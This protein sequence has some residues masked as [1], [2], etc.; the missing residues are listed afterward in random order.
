MTFSELIKKNADEKHLQLL[1]G[2]AERSTPSTE[3][4]SCAEY[5]KKSKAFHRRLR[6]EESAIAEAL[7]TV[8]ATKAEADKAEAERIKREEAERKA[9]EAEKKR[10]EEEKRKEEERK[11]QEEA[12]RRR[13]ER[14]AAERAAR[15]EREA[16]ERAARAERA[17]QE[18]KKRTIR[19]I[20]IAAVS[21]VLVVALI[22][23]IVSISNNK[24][25]E[26]ARLEELNYGDSHISLVI[27][28]KS[29]G[30]QSY[31]NYT[32]NFKVQ[33]NNECGVDIT[34]LTCDVIFTALES[35]TELCSG[36]VWFSG[37]I[38][39][40]GTNK[41]DLELKTS[42]NELWNYSLKDLKIQ[43][44]VTGATFKDGTEKEYAGEYKTIYDGS[45]VHDPNDTSVFNMELSSN[46]GYYILTEV[47]D[48]SRTSYNIPS[49]YEGKPVSAIGSNAFDGCSLLTKVEIPNS[50]L[51]IG[52]NAFSSCSALTSV[53]IPKSV[54]SI[55]G[56]AFSYC[57]DI[58]IYCETASAPSGWDSYWDVMSYDAYYRHTVVWNCAGAQG[59][60][61]DG[62][63]WFA[64]NDGTANIIGFNNKSA[65][66]VTVP[67]EIQGYAIKEIPNELFSGCNLLSAVV[68]SNGIE[69]IGNSAFSGCK[70]LTS[71]TI[72]SS[73]KSIGENAFDGCTS[74]KNVVIPNGVLTIG[75]YAFSDC[76]SLGSIVIPDSVTT[77]GSYIF[78]KCDNLV[79][80]CVTTSQPDSWNYKWDAIEYAYWDDQLDFHT[81]VYNYGGVQ[82]V[83]DDGLWWYATND[84]SAVIAGIVN[85]SVTSLNIPTSING[86]A[87]SEL[88][89]GL[90]SGCKSL[91]NLTIP[92][93]GADITGSSN[94]H[95]GYIF[96]A[97]SYKYNADYI[98]S[99]LKNVTISGGTIIGDN[100]FYNCSSLTNITIPDS[101]TKIGDNAFKNCNSLS[102]KTK[103]GLKYLGNSANPYIY[104]VESETVAISTAT[105]EAGCKYIG[106]GAFLDCSSLTSIVL[107]GSIINIATD[108]FSNCSSLNDVYYNGDVA[109]WV[110]IVFVNNKSTP[111]AY[112]KNL[113]FN[114]VLV[115]S[116][117]IPSS[118]T[119]IGNYAFYNCDSITTLTIADSVT[120]VGNYAF[121]DCDGFAS[122]AVP[123]QTITIG[124]YAFYS[125]SALTTIEM[126]TNSKLETIGDNA[127]VGAKMT[128]ITIPEKVSY[129]GKNAFKSCSNLTDVVFSNTNGWTYAN[130][131]TISPYE[132]SNRDLGSSTKAATYLKSSY[133]DYFWERK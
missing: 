97:G 80:Y 25:E 2:E 94:N 86:Y 58:T 41:F 87:V 47:Q 27:L 17:A 52:S 14:E 85:T 81:V 26:A 36:N 114:N 12:D 88:P 39:K 45:A 15:A 78:E 21:V 107:P 98:P 31:S 16:A 7:K 110:K 99:T 65:T 63:E 100:A 129:I 75:S 32:T 76:D 96:G 8:Q 69:S 10:R 53:T 30:T 1:S 119:S 28:G 46:G 126:T 68:L 132:I 111:M 13:R 6:E 77:L 102:Y 108:A 127:F 121:Y 48:K 44:K 95:F 56:Y 73:V 37:D 90:L 34:Y 38:T 83:T 106:S 123:T 89:K 128:S 125:C 57:G 60:T 84:G 49:T 112:A 70:A 104:L 24:K 35:G 43:C 61:V 91:V 92:F 3:I 71:I 5:D 59:V 82:G 72:P 62:F 116:V 19:N 113:Y 103:G 67:A 122:L 55:G 20:I 42:S 40:G 93:V 4:A 50:I 51:S 33:I 11:Q 66:N 18:K 120:S 109:G 54:T 64:L 23:T 74:I 131:Y 130:E 117:S 101:I 124:S 29:N 79:I 9:K 115:T 22:I 133:C 105:I 118:V